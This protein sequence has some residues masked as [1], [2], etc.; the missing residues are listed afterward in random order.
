MQGKATIAEL[1]LMGGQNSAYLVC[2]APMIPA[3]G[4]YV[5]AHEEGSDLPLAT[6]LFAAEYRSNGFVAAPPIPRA[7]RPGSVLD[8]RGPLGS[9]FEL[10]PG[11]RRVALIA[12]ND[13][14]RRLLPLA[15]AAIRQDAAVALVCGNAPAEL[16]LQVEVH[17]PQALQE[18]CGWSDYAAFD[19]G[20][21]SVGALARA[22]SEGGHPISG[23]PA[24]A[25]VRIPMPCGGLAECGVCTVRTATGPKLACVDGP[26]FDLSLL[27]WER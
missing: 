5:L 7:W 23:G 2:E 8:L 14:P 26:V 27:I 9:G 10:P 17:P 21:E 11:A 12:F 16:P 3:S 20:S 1:S 18:V 19:L 22:L 25:L 24:E 15:S 13:D 4:R 6:E